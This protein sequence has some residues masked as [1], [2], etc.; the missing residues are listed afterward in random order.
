MKISAS[1]Y[2]NKERPVLETVKDLVDHGVD[3]LHIDCNDDPRVFDDIA[4]IRTFTK[5]PI[6][7]HLITPEPEKYYDALHQFQPE[8]VSLQWESMLRHPELPN[9]HN[10]SFGLALKTETPVDILQQASGYCYTMLMSTTPGA[11]GGAFRI[12]NFQR[13]NKVCQQFPRL[14]IQVDGGVNDAIAFILRLQGVQSVVSGSYLMNHQTIG[15]GLLSFYRLPKSDSNILISDFM[16]PLEQTPMVKE[17]NGS[18]LELLQ[19]MEDFRQGYVMITEAN[20]ILKGV[21]SNADLRRGLLKHFHQPHQ[22][23]ASSIMNRT[24]ITISK[25]A[26]LYDMLEK[27]QSL[28]FIILFLP[29]IDESG[30]LCGSVLLNQLVR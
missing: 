26:T 18:F 11:S 24:P 17:E 29:V 19:L 7:L 15:S 30:R 3:M 8:M 25:H 9:I 23:S 14:K 4:A 12:E 21:I 10:T 1:I 6:D 20:G 28:P 27:I 13:I 2:S 5:T 22:L 16:L